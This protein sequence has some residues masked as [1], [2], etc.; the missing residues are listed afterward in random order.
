MKKTAIT[1]ITC[2]ALVALTGTASADDM[3]DMSN[4]SYGLKGSLQLTSLSGDNAK[5]GTDDYE[6]RLGFA[7]GGTGTYK[8]SEDLSV[9][10]ELSYS[11]RG[12]KYEKSGLDISQ[13]FDYIDIPVNVVWTTPELADDLTTKLGLG[14]QASYLLSAETDNAG[15]ITDVKDNL[16]DIDYGLNVGASASIPSP[17]GEEGSISAEVRYYL[18]L[19]EIADKQQNTGI[20]FNA[21]YNF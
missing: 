12:A 21:A 15:T 8:I 7:V 13:K 1:A 17:F 10:G 18:G 11:Q 19:K 5:V 16:S 3:F 4:L 2:A 14:L 20:Q 9:E 6:S